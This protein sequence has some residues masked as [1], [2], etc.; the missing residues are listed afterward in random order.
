LSQQLSN[1]LAGVVVYQKKSIPEKIKEEE[2]ES[3]MAA[4]SLDFQSSF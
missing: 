2:I 4:I 1:H 3:A